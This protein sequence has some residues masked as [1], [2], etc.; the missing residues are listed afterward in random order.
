MSQQE[1]LLIGADRKG[2]ADGQNDAIDRKAVIGRYTISAKRAN[3]AAQPQPEVARHRVILDG[4]AIDWAER[5]CTISIVLL[6]PV[7]RTK[8]FQQLN[9]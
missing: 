4:F 3:R 9:S 8:R 5:N 6:S 7:A 2:P 1:C